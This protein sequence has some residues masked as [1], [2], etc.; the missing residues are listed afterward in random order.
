MAFSYAQG[1]FLD[2][3]GAFLYAWAVCSELRLNS[4]GAYFKWK[5]QTLNYEF[6]E[7]E[8]LE[9]LHG[10]LELLGLAYGPDC[11]EVTS[12]FCRISLSSW[13]QFFIARKGKN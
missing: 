3:E 12:C 13:L 6:S 2:A 11:K 8:L 7:H 10:E 9:S 5:P 1:V 4:D